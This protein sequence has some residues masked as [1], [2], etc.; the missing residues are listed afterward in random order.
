MSVKLH[1]G[2]ISLVL[3]LVAAVGVAAENPAPVSLAN[4]RMQ[5]DGAATVL[6]LEAT[7]PVVYTSYRPSETVL[8]V[9]LPGV[10]SAQASTAQTVDSP[11]VASYRLLPFRSVSGRKVLRLEVNLRNSAVA[12]I[13]HRPDNVVTVRLEPRGQAKSAQIEPIAAP[14]K[15][16]SV[17]RTVSLIERP[18]HSE[19]AIEA[20]GQPEY[21]AFELD[22]P[23]RLVLDLPNTITR[24]SRRF[25]AGEGKPVTAVRI[26]Q[27]KPNPPVTRV[28]IDLKEMQPYKVSTGSNQLRIRFSSERAKEAAPVTPPAVNEPALQFALN[29]PMPLPSYLTATD[30]M[31]AVPTPATAE[32]VKPTE[33][34]V[35]ANFP[36]PEPPRATTPSPAAS[37]AVPEAYPMPQAA[38]AKFTGEPISVNLKDVDLKDFFRLIH[39][40]S[41]LN[42]VLDPNVKGSVT[43]VLDD[44]PWDQA[45]DIVLKNNGLGKELDGNV[46]RIA[47]LSTLKGEEEQRRDLA[48]ARL[49]SGEQVT[50]TRVLSYAKADDLIATLKKFLSP[51]GDIIAD[52]RSNTL[53]IKDVAA[54][55]PEMDNLIKQLDRKTQ[56]VEVEARIVSASRNFARDIGAQFGFSTSANP[57]TLFGGALASSPFTQ[58]GPPFPPLISADSTLPT[59]GGGTAKVSIP[60]VTNLGAQQLAPT[61]GITFTHFEP[62]FRLD[63]ILTAAETK[64]LGKILSKPR[65]ITQNNAE[66]EI[67]QGVR[68]PVQTT[69]NNTISTQFI[70]VVLRLKVTPQITAEGTVFL[71]VEVENTTIDAGIPRI[72][73]VPALDTQKATTKVLVADNGTV[74]I[75][76]IMITN[77]TVSV[78]QTPLFGSIPVL[79]HLFKENFVS[80]SSSE[81]LLFLTPRI[82]ES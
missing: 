7:G 65:I 41:G 48:Q 69:V 24:V 34:V 70:D 22:H 80:T 29:R 50:V 49:Q 11:L 47:T 72:N 75:G 42:V 68:I 14:A 55:L 61:S 46:L 16:G 10:V 30:A 8:V 64:G 25:L 78:R 45:L 54:V 67:K 9:D 27:F 20:E 15:R 40:I 18:D 37:P 79:G 1:A 57:H 81:L 5:A 3:L 2:I 77:N 39:E 33:A 32:A 76:G 60:L 73:G 53:I 56:Q 66:A 4:V 74:V 13:Y 17:V 43:I 26:G 12:S 44:V 28:V 71:D 82:V 58:S 21:K 62:N 19:V 6:V 52:K 31:L 23:A 35:V 36:A 38:K 51:R 59:G 63:F